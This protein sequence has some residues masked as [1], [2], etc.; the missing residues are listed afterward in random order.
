[1]LLCLI[2][3]YQ[4]STSHSSVLEYLWLHWLDM[5]I[6]I[7]KNQGFGQLPRLL[8][9]S[10]LSLETLWVHHLK[11]GKF[12]FL[13]RVFYEIVCLLFGSMDKILLDSCQI[14]ILKFLIM[15][16]NSTCAVQ[17]CNFYLVIMIYK[18]VLGFFF[19]SPQTVKAIITCYTPLE[20][21]CDW[22]DSLRS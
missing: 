4:P 11:H 6:A 5:A 2:L 18:C 8:A 14:R 20:R 21:Y 10:K 9:T 16:F 15:I 7:R 3:Q 22:R 12:D 19:G 17:Q 1:M 13:A